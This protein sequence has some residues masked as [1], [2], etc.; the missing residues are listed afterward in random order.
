MAET[1]YLIRKIETC[2]VCHGDRFVF[3]RDWQEIN[4]ANN[5]WMAERG[6]TTFTD[7]AAA[8]WNL[9]IKEKWPYSKPPSEEEPCC[10]CEGRGEIETWID[11]STAF[12]E[13]GVS[14][15]P[16]DWEEQQEHWA[17]LAA[18]T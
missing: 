11:M 15:H 16:Y 2:P 7:E 10:E 17:R 13:M 9:R 4:E 14:T 3:N 18:G 1:R 12:Q 8:D 6:I 5:A